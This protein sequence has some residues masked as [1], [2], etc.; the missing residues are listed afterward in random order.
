[1][2]DIMNTSGTFDMVIDNK[3][4]AKITTNSW[5]SNGD[6]IKYDNEIYTVLENTE[7]GI[8]VFN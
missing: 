4:I 2:K 6:E 5:L 1:M 8:I 3:V 7:K